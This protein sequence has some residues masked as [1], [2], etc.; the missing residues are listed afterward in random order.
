MSGRTPTPRAPTGWRRRRRDLQWWLGRGWCALGGLLPRAVFLALGARLGRVAA[1]LTPGTRTAAERRIAQHLH[2]PPAEA[3][4]TARAMYRHFGRLAAELALFDRFLARLEDEVDLSPATARALRQR[5]R[6]AG[7]LI[8]ASGHFGNWEL[9]AARLARELRQPVVF[10]RAPADPR[11][12]RWLAELRSRGGVE[13]LARDRSLGRWRAARRAGAAVGLLVDRSTTEPRATVHFL[14]APAPA[15]TAPARLHRATGWPVVVATAARRPD[16]GHRVEVDFLH[17]VPA[18]DL[19]AAVQSALEARL[20][21]QPET[22]IWFHDRWS[23]RRAP[24]GDS[25]AGR[26]G[27]QPPRSGRG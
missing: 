11:W 21:R 26:A 27:P 7:G 24:A 25:A 2:Q 14:G 16:G 10:A 18:A 3:A 15:S 17:D 20:R 5:Q 12:A 13:T 1:V 22:W 23:D 8:V 6:E 19:N 9:M 4:A